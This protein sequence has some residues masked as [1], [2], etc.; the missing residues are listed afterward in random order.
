LALDS[1][2]RYAWIRALTA[3]PWVTSS[4]A[5]TGS[6]FQAFASH[7][8]RDPT[9]LIRAI[10]LLRISSTSSPGGALVCLASAE[11]CYGPHRNRE[12]Y[13][14]LSARLARAAAKPQELQETVGAL[15]SLT[16]YRSTPEVLFGANRRPYDSTF[17]LGLALH[18]RA[19]PTPA[20][21]GVRVSGSNWCCH[22]SKGGP[23]GRHET[24]I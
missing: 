17:Q 7:E 24:Q 22:S 4:F 9:G 2:H 12:K 20:D 11:N 3:I 8:L 14:T 18:K 6:T 23:D 15:A 21:R 1:V 19:S 10:K 13:R 5:G 16:K